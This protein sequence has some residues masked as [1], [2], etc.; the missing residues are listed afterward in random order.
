MKIGLVRHGLTDWNARGIIQGQSDIPLN[1]EGREQAARLAKRLAEESR[2]WDAVVSSDLQR[3]HAT[4]KVIAD[5]LSI[6]LLEPD[7]RWRE[8]HFGEAEGTT[9]AQREARW[10][11]D[12]KQRELGIESDKALRE[13]G[14]EAVRKLE[15]R[16]SGRNILVVSHGSLIAQMLLELCEGLEDIK[17]GN[18][19]YSI[20]EKRVNAWHPLLHNCTRH[21]NE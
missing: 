8:R 20:L 16:E 2:L 21:L 13:R 6:P 17:L 10:G 14:R 18:V 19:S 11:L 3:A 1:D 9:L 4:A 7:M 15:E 5:K 12:W